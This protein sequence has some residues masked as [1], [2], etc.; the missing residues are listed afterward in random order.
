MPQFSE[1]VNGQKVI[2]SGIIGLSKKRTYGHAGALLSSLTCH[3]SQLFMVK[4][5]VVLSKQSEETPLFFAQGGY[6]LKDF[7]NHPEINDTA[8]SEAIQ[9]YRIK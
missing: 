2:L 7:A 6:T 1:T 5:V 3:L 4:A 8:A 9:N